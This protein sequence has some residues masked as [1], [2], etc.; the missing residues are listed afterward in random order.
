MIVRAKGRPQ[1]TTRSWYQTKKEFTRVE[2]DYCA[3]LEELFQVQDPVGQPIPYDMTDYQKEWHSASLNIKDEDAKDILVVKARGISFTTSFSIE[4]IVSALTY[5]DQLIPVIA[6]RYRNAK[7]ILKMIAWLV[8][9]SKLPNKSSIEV[10]ETEIVFNDTKTIIRAYPSGNAADSVRGRR[11]IRGLID[12]Y[13][14]QQHDRE[15]LAAVQD[16]MQSGIGQIIIG[17]TANGRHNNFFRLTQNHH[18]FEFFRYPVFDE[19][20]FNPE[21]SILE[22]DVVPIAPWISKKA[23]ESKRM[24]DPVIFKQEYMCDFLDDSISFF[25]HSLIKRTEDPDLV[26]FGDKIAISDTWTYETPNPIYCGVDVARTTHFTAISVFEEFSIE[27]E[28]STIRKEYIQRA[29]IAIRKTDLP[30]QKKILDRVIKAFPSMVRMRIDQTGLGLGLYEFAKRTNPGIVEGINFSTRIRTG[31]AKRKANIREYML[32]NLKS[33]LEGDAV[34][35]LADELQLHHMT[36]MD[37]T[38]KVSADDTGHGDIIF[39]NALALMPYSYKTIVATPL[40]TKTQSAALSDPSAPKESF[41]KHREMDLSEKI[42]WLKR[43]KR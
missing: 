12:E 16:T 18:S 40:A 22:Q 33:L 4:L 32:V 2:L 19:R 25:P 26:N 37:Y 34:T 28:D 43:Q 39:S 31:E 8:H 15:L 6:Q 36:M 42:K 21:K 10:K 14:F 41:G 3:L 20:K 5:R 9:H 13:A 35:L 1:G 7:D 17:S 11:L 27:L 29:L 24:R 30:A 23:L 38:F